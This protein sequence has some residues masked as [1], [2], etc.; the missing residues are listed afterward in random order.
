MPLRPVAA[1]T[2]SSR[3]PRCSPSH[4]SGGSRVAAWCAKSGV[5][6]HRRASA[7]CTPR[8]TRR[9]VGQRVADCRAPP[10]RR[11][12]RRRSSPSAASRPAT[13]SNGSACRAAGV[14]LRQ[15][16][17]RRTAAW[18]A[19]TSRDVEVRRPA[20]PGSDTARPHREVPRR[21]RQAASATGSMPCVAQIGDAT[22]SPAASTGRAPAAS[23]SSGRCA[24][25][26]GVAPSASKIWICTPVLVTWSSPRMTWV[27]R[28]VDV[29]DH[30]RQRVEE[31]A[32][33]AH[34][35]RIAQVAGLST[36]D[37]PRTRSSQSIGALL[38]AGSASAACGL[39]PPAGLRSSSRR[40]SAARS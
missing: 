20:R 10:P 16:V 37:A 32:V 24:K 2:R 40:R 4:G 7:P 19:P 8:A 25:R 11:P 12:R 1:L 26:G 27:M 5:L 30:R 13:A 9:R 14:E 15:L 23:I 35:H 22:A 33:G 21:A 28:E 38:R 34:Q 36:L 39:R 6:D 3:R 18:R 17:H 31:G 29:V